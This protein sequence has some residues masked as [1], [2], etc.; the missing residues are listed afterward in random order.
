MN[1]LFFYQIFVRIHFEQMY[2][3]DIGV[4]GL[5]TNEITLASQNQPGIKN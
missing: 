2:K 1:T 3:P 5:S 4:L